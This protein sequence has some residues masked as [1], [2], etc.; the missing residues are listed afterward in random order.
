MMTGR[1]MIDAADL[2]SAV[3]EAMREARHETDR[4]IWERY[5]FDPTGVDS[6]G[7]ENDGSG[8]GLAA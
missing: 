2:Q 3:R 8:K 5:F 4:D 6:Q 1:T 7:D